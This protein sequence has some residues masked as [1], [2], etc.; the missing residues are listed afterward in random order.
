MGRQGGGDSLSKFGF[1]P[2]VARLVIANG[3]EEDQNYLVTIAAGV[4]CVFGL[5]ASGVMSVIVLV[6]GIVI[7]GAGLVAIGFGISINDLGL[8]HTLITAG[9][10]A[11]AGGLILVGLAAAVAELTKIAEAVRPRA[12]GRTARPGDAK[13]KPEAPA[14]EPRV[15]P[16][17]AE[18]RVAEVRVAEAAR[19]PEPKPPEPRPVEPRPAEPRVAEPRPAA[20]STLE[21]SASAIERLRSSL[22]RTERPKTEVVTNSDEVPL[23]PNGSNGAHHPAAPA[24]APVA[25]NANGVSHADAAVE[26]KGPRLDFLF[27]SKSARPGQAESFDS[28]WPKRPPK[29]G[30]AAKPAPA[31]R[32]SVSER[33]QSGDASAPM[34][35]ESPPGARVEEP[36]PV[37]ILK[38]GV[39]D[40]MA[41]TLYADGSIEA[42]LP[43]GTVRFGS[44]AE[45]RAHI[46]NNP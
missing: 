17:V 9:A 28:L 34:Q 40:G 16:R 27:R 13:L 5:G 3:E 8:R 20:D 11:L 18:P 43:Q 39:V 38:S 31:E 44:I 6:L 15:E 35:A 42:Q 33:P 24:P 21:V 45:L 7:T 4:R 10:T 19:P 23:S 1:G 22:P 46:E 12:P 37:G 2:I 41:Y 32:P 29:G 30:Q 14:P 25:K 26:A 36:R